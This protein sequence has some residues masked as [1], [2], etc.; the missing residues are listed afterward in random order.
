MTYN[1]DHTE[2]SLV[3]ERCEHCQFLPKHLSCCALGKQQVASIKHTRH[4]VG[5]GV[6]NCMEVTVP[7]LYS[8]GSRVIWCPL[9]G[10]R[11]L[12]ESFDE[13][14]YEVVRLVTR[15]PV[16]NDEVESLV[17]D[18][19]GRNVLSSAKNFQLTLDRKP[20]HVICQFGK[21]G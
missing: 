18:F 12:S 3:Q 13:D 21:I 4:A 6:S 8:D 17:L 19:K 7:G 10:R 9:L 16:W 1:K 14:C 20:E 15:K 11:D 2:W 5:D